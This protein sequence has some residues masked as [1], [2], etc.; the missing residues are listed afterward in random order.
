MSL[1][2]LYFLPS[3]SVLSFYIDVVVTLSTSRFFT[4]TSAVCEVW[5]LRLLQ[6]SI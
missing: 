2:V 6:K 5:D 1:I 4:I 3:T